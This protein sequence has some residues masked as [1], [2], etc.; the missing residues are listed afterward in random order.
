M[1][2]IIVRNVDLSDSK[3]GDLI[4]YLIEKDFDWIRQEMVELSLNKELIAKDF[5]KLHKPKH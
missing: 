5:K 3:F 4:N 1:T 2:N